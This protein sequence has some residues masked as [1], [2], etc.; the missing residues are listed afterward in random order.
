MRFAL[1][2]FAGRIRGSCLFTLRSSLKQTQHTIHEISRN[3]T[4]PPVLELCFVIIRVIS[5]IVRSLCK[6]GP[7]VEILS[8]ASDLRSPP[9]AIVELLVSDDAQWGNIIESLAIGTLHSRERVTS[10]FRFK[11]NLRC[12]LIWDR[13]QLTR[14]CLKKEKP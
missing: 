13:I 3:K 7:V 6:S 4:S 1:W 5:W 10:G 9:E 12:D 2:G 8:D 14:R 11:D